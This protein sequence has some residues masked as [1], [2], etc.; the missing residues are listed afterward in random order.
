MLRRE[1]NTLNIADFAKAEQT[2]ER[3]CFK[4]GLWITQKK[5]IKL[6]SGVCWY[7]K[8]EGATGMVEIALIHN[9]NRVLLS[10]FD[11]DH[12][13]WIPE[14]LDRIANNIAYWLTA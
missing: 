9:E 5:M 4:E 7:L 1:I 10:N 13:D 8:K 6:P 11:G 14:T 2:I 12:A 3:I